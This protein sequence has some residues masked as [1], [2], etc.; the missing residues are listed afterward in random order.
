MRSY[1]R[2]GFTSW[3]LILTASVTFALNVEINA[4]NFYGP[5]PYTEVY[6]RLGTSDL[7]P[8]SLNTTLIVGAECLLIITDKNENIVSFDK[9]LLTQDISNG[10]KDMLDIKRYKW[11][12]GTYAIKLEVKD[13]YKT[14]ATL[15][16]LKNC[17]VGTSD[18]RLS[19]ILPL[20]SVKKDSA[21]HPMVKNGF[22]ME[23]LPF[24]YLD[25]T[26]TQLD[27]YIEAYNPTN[28]SD[29][30]LMYE[31]IPENK[32]G[33]RL[34]K[35]K[36]L[37]NNTIEPMILNISLSQVLSGR[38]ILEVSIIDKEKTKLYTIST[39]C[40]ISNIKADL[41]ALE[42]YNSRFENSF[43]QSLY[44]KEMEYILKAHLP[45]TDQH[46]TLSLKE[47]IKRGNPKSQKQ[48][49]FQLWEAKIPENPEEGFQKYMEVA[50]AVDKKFYIA[51]GYGFQSDRGHLFLKYGK[52]SNIISIDTETD[53]YPYEIWY[54]DYLPLTG[55]TNVRFLF[56]NPTL[57][58]S[59]YVLLH[60]TCYGERINPTW[61]QQ[62]YKSALTADNKT[63]DVDNPT[64]P[65]GWN[66]QARRYFNDY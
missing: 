59:D 20:A 21:P 43:A 34:T 48:F 63:I 33:N 30:V 7:T 66:R 52:P 35:Y 56:Y 49:I 4:Y 10:F 58:N 17:K 60:S 39:D 14:D 38:Y 28:L 40:S 32:L 65:E 44:D 47:V 50:R 1:N 5:E 8:H 26:F 6:L 16:I 13:A 31:L 42:G 9:F 3:I 53:A 41:T 46:Q 25:S 37:K 64:V 45:I 24:H 19:D 11:I 23:P 27:F 61:E 36:K 22:Y 15:E 51:A 57:S 12:P 54:Y 55:Q 62:I 18:A 2:F 29:Q